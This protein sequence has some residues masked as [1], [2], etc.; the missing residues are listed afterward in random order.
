MN[1]IDPI[2]IL[3]L[4]LYAFAGWRRGVLLGGMEML[5]FLLSIF[6]ALVLYQRLA[7]VLE[8]LFGISHNFAMAGAFILLWFTA[9]S[10]L[11]I[12]T[13]QIYRRIPRDARRSKANKVFGII[14]GLIRGII[15]VGLVALLLVVLPGFDR[16]SRTVLDSRIGRPLVEG[17][18]VVENRAQE[19]FGG[20]IRDTLTFL[21]IEPDPTSPE[22]IDLRFRTEDVQV[23]AQAEEEMLRLVNRERMERNLPPLVID[24]ELRAVARMHSRE[25]FARGYFSHQTPEGLS[26]FDRMW[27]AGI[28]FAAAG[29]NLALAPT[30]EMAHNGLMRSPDH[31]ANILNPLFGSVGIGCMR[32]RFHGRMFTQNFTN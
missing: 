30:V 16:L 32:S 6:L 27:R 8:N 23:D 31:R 24:I 9:G 5:T 11:S 20:A 1:W 29:E 25:M 4:M 28:T 22:R 2:I 17:M 26:P 18:S 12:A 3:L 7:P 19:I 10:I 14:P 13:R 21:T 15:L